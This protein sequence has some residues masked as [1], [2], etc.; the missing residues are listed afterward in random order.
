MS[1]KLTMV[2]CEFAGCFISN[3]HLHDVLEKE[4]KPTAGM[5]SHAFSD[6]RLKVLFVH[7]RKSAQTG[8][9]TSATEFLVMKACVSIFPCRETQPEMR[10]VPEIGKDLTSIG[11][12]VWS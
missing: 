5:S 1:G 10:T 2:D 12:L 9:G 8:Q 7:E 3:C 11:T 4:G 6:N